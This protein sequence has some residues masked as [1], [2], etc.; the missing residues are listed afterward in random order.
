M[1]YNHQ[2]L[3]Y[4]TKMRPLTGVEP[5]STYTTNSSSSFCLTDEFSFSSSSSFSDHSSS[6]SFSDH[7]NSEP[8]NSSSVEMRD[9]AYE[10]CRQ[11]LSGEWKNITSD[12][13][14][15]KTVR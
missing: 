4:H 8:A 15:F 6:S 13:M 7:H 9:K 14:V 1:L 5:V 10:I 12:D 11:Y 3:Y 2:H